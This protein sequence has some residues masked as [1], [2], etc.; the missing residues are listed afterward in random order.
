MLC[1]VLWPALKVPQ[2]TSVAELERVYGAQAPVHA[3]VPKRGHG[4]APAQALSGVKV[5]PRRLP[6]L[7]LE[8]GVPG[9]PRQSAP[10]T[11][12]GVGGR[13]LCDRD[14]AAGASVGA[15]T[16]TSG[17]SPLSL[18]AMSVPGVRED[19]LA[20]GGAGAGVAW[21]PVTPRALTV[22]GPMRSALSA[23]QPGGGSAVDTAPTSSPAW[24]GFRAVTAEELAATVAAMRSRRGARRQKG[25]PRGTARGAVLT[26]AGAAAGLTADT[27]ASA[28]DAGS[29]SSVCISDSAPDGRHPGL[30]YAMNSNIPLVHA[31][32]QWNGFRLTHK[33]RWAAMWTSKHLK[34]H[35]FKVG[36]PG[37]R[38]TLAAAPA[39]CFPLLRR[40]CVPCACA[41]RALLWFEHCRWCALA[42]THCAV[43]R[44]AVAGPSPAC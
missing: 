32:F 12:A 23:R 11:G 10:G 4:R 36:L 34:P 33:A 39:R 13:A 35:V 9:V 40:K 1:L 2:M 17:V 21:P 14:A 24:V 26:A 15:S 18:S 8:T 3:H 38:S 30:T 5:A 20:Q 31:T 6:S 7:L 44:W 42:R 27:A 25:V 28:P 19:V 22:G 16:S 43:V 41:A 37:C 29:R